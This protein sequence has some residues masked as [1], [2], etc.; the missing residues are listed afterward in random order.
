MTVRQKASWQGSRKEDIMVKYIIQKKNYMILMLTFIFMMAVTSAAFG[1]SN[2]TV[3]TVTDQMSFVEAINEAESGSVIELQNDIRLSKCLEIPETAQLTIKG[4]TGNEKLTISLTSA[5]YKS[6]QRSESTAM[7]TVH[8]ALIIEGLTLDAEDNMRVMQIDFGGDVT[9]NRGA[10]I[11]NGTLGKD[12]VNHGAGIN[13]EGTKTAKTQLTLND[14]SEVKNNKAYGDGSVHGIGICNYKYGTVIMNGGTIKDN[15]DLT[16]RTARYFSYG[17]G[18]AMVGTEAKFVMNDGTIS[19]NEAKAA[20]GGVYAYTGSDCFVMNG[21]TIT[22]NKTTVTGGG[23]YVGGADATMNGGEISWNTASSNTAAPSYATGGGIYVYGSSE[24]DSKGSFTLKNGIIS[25]NTAKTTASSNDTNAQIGQGGGVMVDGI[26][27]MDG[28]RITE[29]KAVSDYSVGEPATCGG[30][31]SV[32]GGTYPGTLMING[33]TISSNKADYLGGA[34][35]LNNENQK[36]NIMYPSDDAIQYPGFAILQVKGEVH[37]T[38]NAAASGADNVYL[39]AGTLLT[40]TGELSQNTELYVGTEETEKGTIIGEAGEDHMISASDARQLTSN[41]GKKIYDLDQDGKIIISDERTEAYEDMSSAE[42]SGIQDTYTYTGTTIKPVPKVQLGDKVLSLGTDYTVS[43]KASGKDNVNISNGETTGVVKIIGAG[44]YTGIITEYFTIIA[45]DINQI[46]I[47]EISDRIYGGEA[48]TPEVR[49]SNNGVKLVQGTDFDVVYKNNQKVGTGTVEI[50]GKNNYAGSVTKTFN[51]I[52]A[53]GLKTAG[54]QEELTA[55][56]SSSEGTAEDPEKIYLLKDVTLSDTLVIP[57]SAYI[58]LIGGGDQLSVTT[59]QYLDELFRV[60]GQ[61][62][63]ENICVDGNSRSR[64]FYVETGGKLA[65]CDNTVITRGNATRGANS[66]KNSG[67]AVYNQGTLQLIAGELNSNVAENGGAVFNSG[68][69]SAGNVS[70]CDNTASMAGGAVYNSGNAVLEK[71]TVVSANRADV[72]V[73]VGLSGAGGAIYNDGSLTCN[74]GCL[75]ENNRAGYY[76]GGVYTSGK[77]YIK[78][79][80]ICRNVTSGGSE[81][82]RGQ[83]SVNCGGGVF[84][85][86]GTLQ[87]DSGSIEENTAKSTYSTYTPGASYANG[88]G[89]YISNR[90]E[91]GTKVIMNGGSICRNNAISI[92]NSEFAGHGGGVFILGGENTESEDNII[93]PGIFTMNDGNITE[94][95][96]SASGSGVYLSDKEEYIVKYDK[97]QYFG[98]AVCSVQGSARICENGTDNVYLT[99]N[100][101]LTLTGALTDD[102][103]LGI[104]SARGG[105]VIVSEGSEYVPTESDA[106]K[107]MGDTGARTIELNEQN[108]IILKA[109]ELSD[110][111]AV[112]LEEEE[113]IYTGKE[114]KPEI[115]VIANDKT[116][117]KENQDFTVRY[118]GTGT[119]GKK[120]INVGTKQVIVSGIGDYTGDI[121]GTY[122]I[123]SRDIEEADAYIADQTYTGAALTPNLTSITYNSITLLKGT[124][125]KATY[126]NNVN[127]GM[128]SVTITGYG[129]FN[130]DKIVSFKIRR[131]ISNAVTTNI[132]AKAYTGKSL[133]PAVKVTLGKKQL[134]AGTDYSIAYKNNIVPGQATVTITGKG[135]YSGTKTIKF[136]IVPKKA[137]VKKT[138]SSKKGQLTVT[139]VKDTKASGYQVMVAYN[140][141]FTKGKKTV[142]LTKNTKVTTTIKNL[143]SKKTYYVKV[144]SYK[145][146]SGKKYYGSYSKVKTIKVK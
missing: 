52:S 84:V 17:G 25:N 35:Y 107:Y 101:K 143:K 97:Y 76:G 61:L 65:V 105:D 10:V 14:G 134:K 44:N 12:S 53:A 75:I 116:I 26:F 124:D 15:K 79:A 103:S 9:L 145:T 5:E 63:V 129:N 11:M 131:N 113:F 55:I 92:M 114:I 34:V 144:R 74:E 119:S 123:I 96:A 42:V 130:G 91:N 31:I 102:A 86:S 47:E 41:E 4:K 141:K 87:M 137:T 111:A 94:N 139:C 39:T 88:G 125:Y 78:G 49:A 51:I 48:V 142:L 3:I 85:F 106:K 135:F 112:K 43:Y 126:T 37:I 140:S 133:T 20:G 64:G 45:K 108:Q 109:I 95:Y 77:M 6:A 104:T 127:E 73:A 70:I 81:G 57:S 71:G 62:T 98:S 13:M 24:S 120:L 1:E 58:H 46:Q 19:G 82:V 38:D 100:T 36:A 59:S 50:T 22:E 18:I 121:S 72:S 28:G 110:C 7:V 83:R 33:G 68:T 60:Q 40:V 30:G 56:I 27:C 122:E 93:K 118:D 69:F 146:I 115:Q 16:E 90:D 89:I 2:E 23:V 128:A 21:G 54:T 132:S 66:A 32:K 138:A 29:N 8:G 99:E 117:L 67:G 136:N 80:K